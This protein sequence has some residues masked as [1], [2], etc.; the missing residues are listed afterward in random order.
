[1]H[2]LKAMGIKLSMDD[3]GTGYSSFNYLKDFPVDY[4]KLDYLF[5]RDI[6]SHDNAQKIA[7]AMIA[8]AKDL[9]LTVVAEGV[10]TVEQ[11]DFLRANG[12]D[13]VQ[14]FYFSKP[15][16]GEKLERAILEK[17]IS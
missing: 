4:L 5:I 16:E 2:E 14:G 6:T 8:L 7:I 12:C 13:L 1:M 9:G 10:E 15:L 17:A 3:F 11:L